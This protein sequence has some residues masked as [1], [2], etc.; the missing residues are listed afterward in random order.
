[1]YS[2]NDT[3]N[4]LKILN[5]RFEEWHGRLFLFSDA[6]WKQNA[7]SNLFFTLHEQQLCFWIWFWNRELT[8]NLPFGEKKTASTAELPL[9]WVNSTVHPCSRPSNSWNLSLLDEYSSGIADIGPLENST[10]FLEDPPF[11]VTRVVK[12]GILVEAVDFV[13]S[14]WAEAPFWVSLKNEESLIEFWSHWYKV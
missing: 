1:M 3:N 11:S 8:I 6:L 7:T 12:P 9:F 14:S 10:V 4:R 2:G 5:A 13:W